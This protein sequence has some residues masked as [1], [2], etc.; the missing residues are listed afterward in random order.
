M[1][2]TAALGNDVGVYIGGSA[3]AAN[4]N[5]VGGTVAAD[6]NVISGN[7]GD[8]IQINAGSGGA[9]SNL[10]QGNYIGVNVNGTVALGNGG[11]GVGVFTSFTNTNNVI[12]GTAPGA[13]N[14]ISGSGNDG[15]LIANAG[16]TG[17]LVQGNRIGTDAAGAAAIPNLRG[18]EFDASTS[19]NTIGG[20]AAGAPNR[21]AY[22]TNGGVETTGVA[23]TGNQISAN[24]I[25]S[26]GTRGIDLGENGVT[27]NDTLDG[28]TGP[29]SLQNFPVLSAAMTNGAG[30]ANVAG[31]LNS[32]A[33]TT[34]RIE[35][36]ASSAADGSGYGEGQRYLGFTNVTTNATGNAIIGVTLATS[37][38][39]GEFVTATATDPL[40]NTSEFSNTVLAYQS[41]IVTTTA[42]TSDGTT[43][44]VSNLI[45]NPGADGRIS[46]REAIQATNA[47]AGTDTIRFG[48]PL[49]DA[50]HRYYRNDFGGGV[51]DQCPGDD[52][53]RLRDAV[54]AG[55]HRLR[56]R[57]PGGLHA[58]LVPDPADT[59]PAAT[60]RHRRRRDRR[61][62]AAR[63]HRR[64]RRW[65]SWTAPPPA[66]QSTACR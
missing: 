12:G 43:T 40:N 21:I 42:N 39:A 20:T 35:F 1:A 13:G 51:P 61:G 55:N 23:G 46:L 37:L 30:S 34:Y 47:S 6:R 66:R 58:E 29:N 41:L 64:E 54:L 10:V 25:Y 59:R 19:G 22:N 32:A 36:F 4:N 38:T 26:N 60:E 50:N 28:D 8:G 5:R 63:I 44:S 45:A 17:T 3:T 27:A 11:Q 52:T 15:V 53:R 57:L 7:T 49:T 24:E 31:S 65:S 9:V 14:V 62:D 16:T 18:V 2:G 56:P 33:S 48:I